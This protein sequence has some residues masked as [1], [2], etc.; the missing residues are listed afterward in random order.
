MENVEEVV[1][2]PGV[3]SGEEEPEIIHTQV[4]RKRA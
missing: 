3:V 4:E 2:S 1:I